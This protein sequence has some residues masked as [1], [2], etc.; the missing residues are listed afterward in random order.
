MFLCGKIDKSNREIQVSISIV[1]IAKKAG[2]SVATVSRALNNKGP[3][4]PKT[5]ARIQQIAGQFNYKPNVNARGLLLHKTDTIGLILPEL[6]DEF[7]MDILRGVDEAATRSGYYVMLSSSHSRRDLVETMLEFMSS[8][9]VDGI[10]LM[11]PMLH[12]DLKDMISGSSRPIVLLNNYD[13][14]PNSTCVNIKNFQGAYSMTEHL[15]RQGHK[16]IA[17]IK[18]P[19]GNG[20]ANQRLLGFQQAMAKNKVPIENELIVSGDF[21]SKSGYFAFMRLI[22]AED[23]PDAIFALNDMMAVGCFE[24]ARANGL[25]IPQDIA[26]AGFDDIYLTRFLTPRLTTVHTPIKELGQR[27]VN[28]LLK[29]IKQE[30]DPNE[31][32]CEEIGT[33][34]IIGGTCGADVHI[35]HN[36]Y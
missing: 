34:L 14:I 32:H 17:V 11:T 15:I 35:V 26:L 6:A 22:N 18:G 36:G 7:F 10:I 31:N 20:D 13:Q 16:R 27:A 21:S 25:S 5:R 3:V 2:V 23:K 24:A 28:Y 30:V 4:S 8:G 19:E 12:E 29:M 9:R 33:G 1:E